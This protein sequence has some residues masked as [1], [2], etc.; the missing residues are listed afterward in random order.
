MSQFSDQDICQYLSYSGVLSSRESCFIPM[1]GEFPEWTVLLPDKALQLVFPAGKVCNTW[2][3]PPQNQHSFPVWGSMGGELRLPFLEHFLTAF[4]INTNWNVTL[5]SDEM[6]GRQELFL[7]S[8]LWRRAFVFSLEQHGKGVF[9]L[10][11]HL[12][13]NSF[14]FHQVFFL[15]SCNLNL[16]IKCLS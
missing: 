4:S 16:H 12:Y 5:W 8:A 11:T 14:Y 9:K 13:L 2:N 15:S 3:L 10:T 6:A 7:F 1:W